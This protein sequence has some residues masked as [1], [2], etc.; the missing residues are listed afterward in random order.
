[1]K[2]IITHLLF[3]Y[4]FA[5]AFATGGGSSTVKASLTTVTVFRI[6]A[7]MNH[8]AKTDLIKGNKVKKLRISYNVK[9]PK[10]KILNL[11]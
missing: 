4:C 7:E 8:L 3:M 1:M 11:N 10:D 6:G 2:K 9:Y 5:S